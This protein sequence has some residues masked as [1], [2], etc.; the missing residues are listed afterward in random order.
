MKISAI[1]PVLNAKKTL[2]RTIESVF[3]QTYSDWQLI[4]VDGGSSD[5]TL[6]IIQNVNDPRVSLYDDTNGSITSAVNKGIKL[7][8]GDIVMPW[9]CADDYID[10]NFFE[11]TVY[12]FSNNLIDLTYSSWNAI[13]GDLA[14]KNRQPQ[15]NWENYLTYGMPKIMSNTFI[16]K[17][18]IFDELGFLDESIL[19][20]NDYEFI[21][22]CI[23]A[24]KLHKMVKETCYNYSIGGLSQSKL[25]PCLIEVSRIAIAFGDSKFMTYS[26]LLYKWL[27]VK[28]SFIVNS[29]RQ[30]KCLRKNII[31]KASR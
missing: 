7:S 10:S 25:L 24:N 20:A 31:K 1:I 29:L 18:T 28:I 2:Q 17:K 3:N 23:K 11:L 30:I 13:N 15:K 27:V 5:G 9:L 8:K 21:R 22:R 4:L 12:E 6:E 26:F 16:F 19:Y 14:I